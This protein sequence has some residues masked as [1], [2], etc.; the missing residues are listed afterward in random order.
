MGVVYFLTTYLQSVMGYTALEAGIRMLPVARG[1]IA[2]TK[3]SV[4]ATERLGTKI[5]VAVGLATVAGALYC[6]AP[7]ASTPATA[8]WR[9]RS[10]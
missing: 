6:S 3:L 1:L 5:V 9:W 4:V 8:A 2:A 10:P 7:A